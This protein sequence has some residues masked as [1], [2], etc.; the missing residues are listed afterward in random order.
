MAICIAIIFI[1]KWAK[2]LQNRDNLPLYAS[3][4][5]GKKLIQDICIAIIFIKMGKNITKWR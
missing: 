5:R 4:T 3:S 1:K 2:I